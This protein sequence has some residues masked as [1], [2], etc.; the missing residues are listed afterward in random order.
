LEKENNIETDDKIMEPLTAPSSF[1]PCF[2]ALYWFLFFLSMSIMYI[3]I[4]WHDHS[5]D[6]GD[7]KDY[8]RNGLWTFNAHKL[9][10]FFVDISKISDWKYKQFKTE[11]LR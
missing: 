2:I 3:D 8:S 5:L 10:R 1:Y 11:T 4:I 7:L 6:H 9:D